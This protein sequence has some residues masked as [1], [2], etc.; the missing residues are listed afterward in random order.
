MAI[1]AREHRSNVYF[2][3]E[4]LL[5]IMHYVGT[6][7]VV[8]T[9]EELKISPR[10]RVAQLNFVT[11]WGLNLPIY[12]WSRSRMELEQQFYDILHDF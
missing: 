9:G 3:E 4:D 8:R 2:W 6:M 1:V 11:D 7:A 10:T 12:F 5:H